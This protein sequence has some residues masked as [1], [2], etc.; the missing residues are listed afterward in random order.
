MSKGLPTHEAACVEAAV[1]KLQTSNADEQGQ[2]EIAGSAYGT[3]TD[4][5]LC[6][7]D[8]ELI[9]RF[10]GQQGVKL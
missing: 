3:Q 6:P 5:D 10:T 8:R 4:A 7:A 9:Y 2:F 1:P